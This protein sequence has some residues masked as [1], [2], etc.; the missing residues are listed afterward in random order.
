MR[1]DALDQTLTPVLAV[2]MWI[3]K[4][5][6][7]PGR[8]NICILLCGHPL[9]FASLYS[10]TPTRGLAAAS[11]RAR[12]SPLRVKRLAVPLCKI[13][14]QNC[15]HPLD[16]RSVGGS[17]GRMCAAKS[18]G[19]RRE[20]GGGAAERDGAGEEGGLAPKSSSGPRAPTRETGGGRA[21][22]RAMLFR[23]RVFRSGH[24]RSAA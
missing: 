15:S 23:A 14:L 11:E 8:S 3:K 22:R 13:L 18:R 19:R 5:A 16:V 4:N 20:E 12:Q 17:R 2:R 7:N 21:E 6:L 9:I 24:S 10:T 1:K